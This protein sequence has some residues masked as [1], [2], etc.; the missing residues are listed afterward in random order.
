VLVLNFAR[1][2]GVV[3]SDVSPVD[4]LVIQ[5]GKLKLSALD[6]Q[7]EE[8]Y[9]GPVCHYFLVVLDGHLVVYHL[10][11]QLHNHNEVNQK[12]IDLK[13]SQIGGEAQSVLHIDK[14]PL[15]YH[16]P[17]KYSQ[18][19]PELIYILEDI[20]HSYARTNRAQIV[21]KSSFLAV[22]FLNRTNSL[23]WA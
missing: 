2:V 16:D 11:Q 17:S 7:V 6:E 10:E 3:S 23:I 21:I 9:V 14:L 1:V 8:E 12:L 22:A 18:K 5:H 4:A 15:L 19:H 13:H 20:E